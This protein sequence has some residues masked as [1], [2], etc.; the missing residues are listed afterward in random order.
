MNDLIVLGADGKPTFNYNGEAP[1]VVRAKI[2]ELVHRL[3]ALPKGDQID[4]PVKHVFADGM[5]M[6][7]LFIPKDSMLVGK[8]HKKECIN[9]VLKG[10][11]SVLT[12]TGFM[13]VQAGFSIVSPAGLQKVGIA[14]EDT[15]FTNIFLNPTNERDIDK[16][17]AMI[18][19]ESFDDLDPMVIEGETSCQ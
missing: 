17:E 5:Y 1:L 14:H 10:D 6:R 7:E 11:I 8:I 9:I 19:S 16:L 13:R 18:A 2:T 3:L 12:E 15:I 4:F